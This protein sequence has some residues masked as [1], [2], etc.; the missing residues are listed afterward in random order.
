MVF[1]KHE[2]RCESNKTLT[3]PK[4]GMTAALQQYFFKEFLG[5]LVL[6]LVVPFYLKVLE[7]HGWSLISELALQ[8]C[9]H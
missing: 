6:N 5:F 7:L 4:I 8:L 1:G 2:V 3:N 9:G